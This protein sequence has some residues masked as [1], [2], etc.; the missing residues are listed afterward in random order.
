MEVISKVKYIPP[1]IEVYETPANI[2]EEY[3]KI[4]E[5]YLME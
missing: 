1:V 5:A 2:E 3:Q 4:K